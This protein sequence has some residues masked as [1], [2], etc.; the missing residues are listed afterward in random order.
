MKLRFQN[1]IRKLKTIST[2]AFNI[3]QFFAALIAIIATATG[4]AIVAWLFHFQGWVVP[5]STFLLGVFVTF[6]LVIVFLLRASPPRWV[7]GG[8]KYIKIDCLYIIHEDDPKHH[9]YMFEVEIEAIKSG[10][11]IFESTYRWTGHGI[12]EEPKVVSS[13]HILL[14]KI[15]KQNGWKFYYIH[16]GQELKIGARTTVKIRQELHD[17]DNNFE[18]YLSKVVSLPMDHITLHVV[19]PK[20]LFPAKIFFREWDAAGPAGRIIREAPGKINSHSGE[21]RWEIPSPVFRHRFS[22]DW[23]YP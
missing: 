19:L 3:L 8:Y 10:V 6:V 14:G 15:I 17:A 22:I 18:P 2:L 1:L 21:I 20:A 12:E 23:I 9:T 13:G 11:S 7:L 16:L 5:L 4:T